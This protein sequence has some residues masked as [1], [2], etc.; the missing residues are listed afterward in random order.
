MAGKSNALADAILSIVFNAEI[1][2]SMEGLFGIPDTPLTNLYVSLH[3]SDPGDY[4]ANQTVGECTYTGYARASRARDSAV[5]I[6]SSGEVHFNTNCDF[7]A[8][9]GATTQTAT[10][11]AIGT[12]LSGAG[13]TI[14]Y[15][16]P[17]L[18][19]IT[20]EAGDVPRLL[21]TTN[22]TEA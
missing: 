14:L 10:H 1:P 15:S 17:I 2:T 18:P 21:P 20:I 5:F 16:G 3:T 7:P 13:G 6:P 12:V 8:N 19:P 9:G 11:F 4:A 22:V